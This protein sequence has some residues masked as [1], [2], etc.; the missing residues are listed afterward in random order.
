MQKARTQMNSQLANTIS[1]VVG[2]T[3]QRIL[4]TI[5]TGE[6]KG[7]VLTSLKNTR[8]HASEEEIAKSL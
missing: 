1:D 4:R 5:N 3:G 7:H 2:E 8:I 6:R